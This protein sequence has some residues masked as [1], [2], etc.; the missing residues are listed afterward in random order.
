MTVLHLVPNAKEPGGDR[1]TKI[2]A[3][4]IILT[5]GGARIAGIAA[6]T[7]ILLLA[8]IGAVSLIGR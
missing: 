7:L 4:L 3:I 8:A 6:Y 5:N 1:A 2:L